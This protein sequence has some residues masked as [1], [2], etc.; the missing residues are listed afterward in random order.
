MFH[1]QLLWLDP[2]AKLNSGH[3]TDTSPALICGD[4]GALRLRKY[5]AWQVTEVRARP[6]ALCLQ[7]CR[8]NMPIKGLVLIC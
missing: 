5:N 3:R 4:E 6:L 8:C 1:N 7:H 2:P